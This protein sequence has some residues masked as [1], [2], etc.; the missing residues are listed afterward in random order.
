MYSSSK[1]LEANLAVYLH[2]KWCLYVYCMVL[3]RTLDIEL[4]T[5]SVACIN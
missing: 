3:T 5:A 1:E 2:A 4:N